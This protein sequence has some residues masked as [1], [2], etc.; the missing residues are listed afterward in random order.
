M[1]LLL[2]MLGCA[3]G[4]SALVILQTVTRSRAENQERNKQLEILKLELERVAQ[5][6]KV[7]RERLDRINRNTE[8]FIDNS[9]RDSDGVRELVSR[10]K[11][12]VKT[13]L[14][15][16]KSIQRDVDEDRKANFNTFG[17]IDL[18][19][20][21]LKDDYTGTNKRLNKVDVNIGA[22]ADRID[23]LEA[24]VTHRKRMPKQPSP[25]SGT[26]E[27]DPAISAGGLIPLNPEI[28]KEVNPSS[29]DE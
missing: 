3:I 20:Q 25:T 28:F 9:N 1:E 4:A 7:V 21:L 16:A 18:R 26:T 29:I 17:E 14:D 5:E 24:R 8:L 23:A 2:I 12:G 22:L 15:T 11:E 10:L 13:A 6:N 19:Q 27:N